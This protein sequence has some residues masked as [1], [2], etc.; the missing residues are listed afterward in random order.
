MMGKYKVMLLVL[1]A[2][3]VFS[4]VAAAGASAHE[5]L[6]LAG[7]AIGKNENST[8]SGSWALKVKKIPALEGGG[9]LTTLCDGQLLGS[10][11]PKGSDTVTLVESLTGTEQDK[12][13]CEV[14]ASTNSICK[15]GTL[16][17]VTPAG[18][19]WSTLLILLGT[20]VFDDL[21]AKE[22]GYSVTCSSITNKCTVP[23]EL[24]KF[25]K[26]VASGAEF[27]FNELKIFACSIGGEGT[28]KG[29]FTTLNFL[30]N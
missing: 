9:E 27:E 19:P 8:T 11:G 15:A 16:V 14:S 18:L 30:A 28:I 3:F 25:I 6:T 26:N 1:L 5:W 21:A 4:A 10:V 20:E 23:L 24:S 13:K 2:A 17:I 22:V 7:V 12:L 29:R